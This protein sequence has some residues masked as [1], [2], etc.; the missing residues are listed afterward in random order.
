M[1]GRHEASLPGLGVVLSGDGSFPA[2][3]AAS[4]ED[5]PRVDRG[6]AIQCKRTQKEVRTMHARVARF[7]GARPEEADEAIRIVRERYLPEFKGQPG[8]AGYLLLIDR[9]RGT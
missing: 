7:E 5:L 1:P 4:G 3:P 8:F 6:D 2:K 9:D